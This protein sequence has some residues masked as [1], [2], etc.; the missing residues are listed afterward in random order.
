MADKEFGYVDDLL[1]EYSYAIKALCD[2]YKFSQ[3]DISTL[4]WTFE[5]FPILLQYVKRIKNIPVK[6]DIPSQMSPINGEQAVTIDLKRTPNNPDFGPAAEEF[7]GMRECHLKTDTDSVRFWHWKGFRDYYPLGSSVLFVEKKDLRRFYR[8]I[9]ILSRRKVESVHPVLPK[10]MLEEIYKN[11]IGFLLRRED[12]KDVY[13]KFKIPYKRG[14]LLCGKPGCGK[15]LTCK[16]VRAL[17]LAKGIAHKIVTM[18]DYR[19][20]LNRGSVSGLF[21]LAAGQKGIIFFDDMDML[22][23]DR[24][25]GNVEILTFLTE[26]DGINPT[27]GIVFIFTTNFVK[28]LDEAFVR[29]GRIDLFLTFKPPGIRLRKQFVKECFEEEILSD[30]DADD[31]VQRTDSYTFA[32]IEEIRKLFAI[33]LIDGKTLSVDR[34]FKIFDAHRKEFEERG[35][36]GF[37]KMD[38]GDVDYESLYADVLDGIPSTSW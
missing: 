10:G 8:A 15:T 3:D 20:G 11:S 9:I 5:H 17:C 18:E 7:F 23:K 14:I 27:E 29:P 35:E 32:E 6:M 4:K 38:S 24:N 21:R 13:K 37:G 33:D 19:Q 25:T 2:T 26:L 34:T 22:V 12:D 1:A 28:E 31:I 36:L 16:W 30:M